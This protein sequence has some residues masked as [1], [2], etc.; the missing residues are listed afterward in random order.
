MSLKV[1]FN[2]FYIG[3][4]GAKSYCYLRP[5]TSVRP[6]HTMYFHAVSYVKFL[7]KF[8]FSLRFWLKGDKVAYALSYVTPCSRVLL[9][10]L[11][12]LQLV[13]KFPTFYATQSVITA[14]TRARHL[15]LPIL[16][17]IKTIHAPHPTCR[18]I[19][20]KVFQVVSFHHV[21]PPK[22]CMHLFCPHSCHMPSLSHSFFHH[23]NVIWL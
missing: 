22:P 15:S 11:T 23:P 8:G 5:Q 7:L 19:Y 4:S 3:F 6:S 12:G 14:F 17:Q 10:K 9:E 16:S 21:S 20:A 13:K 2:Y 18:S 1:R